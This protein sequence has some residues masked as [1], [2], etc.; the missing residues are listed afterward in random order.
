MLLKCA[1][2]L[3][4]AVCLTAVAHAQ[5]GVSYVTCS[6]QTTFR[7]PYVHNSDWT[8][9]ENRYTKDFKIDAGA[10]MVFSWNNR[11]LTWKPI[12]PHAGIA[13]SASWGP[14]TISLD[15]MG[16]PGEVVAPYIDFRRS[17]QLTDRN[18]RV[19][20]VIA[21]FGQSRD[22]KANGSW[23]YDGTC[24]PSGAPSTAPIGPPPYGARVGNPLY[25]KASGP[26]L[27]VSAAE[28]RR[29]IGPYIGNSM[30]GYSGGGHWFHD[31]F[32]RADPVSSYTSDDYDISSEGKPRT[33]WVGKDDTGYRLCPET[34]VANDTGMKARKGE[35]CYPLL[36]KKLGD[37]WVEH[38]MDGDAYFTLLAG[39]Q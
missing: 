3:F 26:A 6:V 15:G 29:V 18:A 28:A 5:P 24:Q 33:W 17:I 35:N 14:N 4:G 8:H 34:D 2:A 22:G 32:F 11:S 19:G 20:Y 36:E 31:W 25:Q 12:C 39:R 37:S 1:L 38:D 16:A 30:V 27:P 21:D 23:S 13:C 9:T 10:K 7:K